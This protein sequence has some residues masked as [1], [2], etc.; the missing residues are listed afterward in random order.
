LPLSYFFFAANGIRL[1]L[2]RRT[3]GLADEKRKPTAATDVRKKAGFVTELGARSYLISGIV[4]FGW[5]EQD[6]GSKS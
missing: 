4:V 6:V 5:S 1:L 2:Q 3:D